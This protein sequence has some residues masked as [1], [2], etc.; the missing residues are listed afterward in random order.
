MPVTLKQ[1]TTA[2]SLI[3]PPIGPIFK[4]ALSAVDFFYSFGRSDPA[5]QALKGILDAISRN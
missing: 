5:E 2:T 4:G 1:M 3:P